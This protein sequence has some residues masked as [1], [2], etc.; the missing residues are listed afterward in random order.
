MEPI[1]KYKL[2]I[3]EKFKNDFESL[4]KFYKNMYKDQ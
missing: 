1:E 2:K 4:I 3:K